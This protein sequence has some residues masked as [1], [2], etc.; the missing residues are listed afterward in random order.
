LFVN[1]DYV[2]YTRRDCQI[3]RLLFRYH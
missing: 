1:S 2:L 3:Y